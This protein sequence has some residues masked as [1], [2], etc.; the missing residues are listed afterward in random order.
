MQ[1]Q[2]PWGLRDSPALQPDCVPSASQCCWDPGLPTTAAPLQPDL[3]SSHLLQPDFQWSQSLFPARLTSGSFV[4]RQA[5]A[6]A[7]ISAWPTRPQSH[8]HVRV[9]P[10]QIVNCLLKFL[11]VYLVSMI[12]ILLFQ[13]AY[14]FLRF[15][16]KYLLDNYNGPGRYGSEQEQVRFPYPHQVSTLQDITTT[17]NED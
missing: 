4:G 14:K 1:G 2:V 11:I 9:L 17:C 15:H 13:V 16:N 8:F 5:H 12:K 6:K 10:D 7:R 3:G